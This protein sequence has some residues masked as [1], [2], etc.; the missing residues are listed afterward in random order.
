MS[1]SN[2]FRR[3]FTKKHL[4]KI[5]YSDIRYRGA[6]GIDRINRS[7]FYKRH[8]DYIDIILRKVHDGSYEFSLYLEKLI[9]KGQNKPPRLISIP[10]FRD[11]LTLK[12]LY[13]V[14]SLTFGSSSTFLHKTVSDVI[15]EVKSKKYNAFLKLDVKDFYPSINHEIL[16]GEIKKKVKKPEI[17]SLIENAISR[18]TI[19]KPKKGI[20]KTVDKG[21]PQGLSI[22]NILANI[23]MALIDE[24]HSDAENYKYFRYVD[25]ILVLCQIE[26]LKKIKRLIISD[27][28]DLDLNVHTENGDSS[29][30]TWGIISELG[31]DFDYLGYRF[32]PE[33]LS[34]RSDSIDRLRESIIKHLT[35]FK[36]T[37]TSYREELLKWCLNL[38][39]TGCVLNK[40]KYGWLFY[41][42]QIDDKK[43]LHSLDLFIKKQMDRFCVKH[44]A[45]KRFVRAYYEISEKFGKTNYIP[46]FDEMTVS[47]QSENL[48]RV[49]GVNTKNMKDDDIEFQFKKRIF[50]FVKELEKDLARNS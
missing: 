28:D 50:R 39:I 16:L 2:S 43:L 12:A 23:Y 26:D 14:L 17:L 9:S 30:T 21:V 27:L 25:D 38:R 15:S 44:L 19:D 35:S 4:Y 11:K 7:S 1:A 31:E 33:V 20:K 36:F 47:K 46:N 45:I 22:S 40:T 13:E 5:Y 18:A 8:N 24:K 32:S 48:E 41:F 3:V 6:P 34:V 49:F 29:K 42:S 37:N 10:T